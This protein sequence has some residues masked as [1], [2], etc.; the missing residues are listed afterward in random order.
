MGRE[1]ARQSGQLRGLEKIRDPE[2]TD[3]QYAAELNRIRER[4]SPLVEFC[5]TRESP[6]ESAQIMGRF[7]TAF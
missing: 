4:F 2:Y 1:S 7:Q 6:C 3:E 5:K